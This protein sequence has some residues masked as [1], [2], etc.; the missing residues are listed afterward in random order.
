LY[1]H[2]I[3][4]RD[5]R[6]ESFDFMDDSLVAGGAIRSGD[7]GVICLFD[8]G[9][10]RRFLGG[11]YAYLDGQPLHPAQ[12]DELVARIFYDQTVLDPDAC[13]VTYYWNNSLNAVVAQTLGSPDV[14]PYLQE[15]HDPVRQARM[16]GFYASQEPRDL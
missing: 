13:R 2:K 3:D 4:L 10:H 7:V 1:V 12:F 8:A 15:L 5:D 11:R 6:F 9:L 14:D 16:L